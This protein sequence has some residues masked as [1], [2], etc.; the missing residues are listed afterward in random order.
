MPPDHWSHR[1]TTDEDTKKAV[2]VTVQVSQ[3]VQYPL[4]FEAEVL[5]L[6]LLMTCRQQQFRIHFLTIVNF[7]AENHARN[8]LKINLNS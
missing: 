1:L 5:G 8:K 4:K 2:L 6:S 3:F 7:K